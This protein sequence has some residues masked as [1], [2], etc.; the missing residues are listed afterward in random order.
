MKR[1]H[2]ESNK[3]TPPDL[4]EV[5]LRQH[6]FDLI[7]LSQP[8]R[9]AWIAGMAGSGK[10][11]L[12]AGFIKE[13]DL[14]CLWYRMD[15]DDDDLSAFFYYLGLAVKKAS[16][17]RRK[18]LPLFTP[19]YFM[20]ATAFSRRFFENVG[21]RLRAPFVIVFDDYQKV[22]RSS[23]FHEVLQNGL[24]MLP[25]DIR[26]IISSR[27]DP[28]A[29]YS[30]MI[31]GKQMIIID[32]K[33]LHLSFQETRRILR[34]DAPFP[35]SDTMVR[36]IHRAAGGWAAG[37]V[38]MAK[39]IYRDKTTALTIETAIPSE[40]FNYFAGELFNKLDGSTRE[41]LL[42][43][44]LLPQFTADMAQK[45][46]GC[47]DTPNRLAQ[48]QQDHVFIEKISNAAA[49]YQYHALFRN[50]L[51]DKAAAVLD[52]KI[53]LDLKKNSALLL[54]SSER[55]EDAVTLFAEAGDAA[56]LIRIILENAP[57]QIQLGRSKT[58]VQW[59]KR[60]PEDAREKAPWL[61]YWLGMGTLFFSPADAQTHFEKAFNHFLQEK[62]TI[63]AYLAWAGV[64]DGISNSWNDFNQFDP[65]I[66]WLE[67]ALHIRPTLPPGYIEAKVSVCMMTALLIRKPDHPDLPRWVERALAFSY[68]SEE[69]HLHVQAI[70][71]AM[72]YYAWIGEFEKAE[73]LRDTS[74]AMISSYK[75]AP[76]MTIYWKWLDISTR[77]STMTRIDTILQEIDDVLDIIRHTGLHAWEH[78]FLMP[79][80]FAA[81]LL[82]RL[83]I[84]DGFLKRF[85]TI[86]DKSHFHGFAIYHHFA[87]LYHLLAGD[88]ARA[89]ANSETAVK[90]SR[91]S[92][93]VLATIVCL[94][95][96]AFALHVQ[97]QTPAARKTIAEALKQAQAAKSHIYEF[98]C[99]MVQSRIILAQDPAKGMA[100]L[101]KALQI[102]RQHGYLNMIWWWQPELLAQLCALALRDGI[103]THYV[104][105]LIRAHS[106]L[107]ASDEDPIENW[108]YPI[109]ITTFNRFQILIDG[110]V[111]NFSRKAPKKPLELLQAVI[112]FGGID[113][114]LD[115][116]LDALWYKTDG[117]MAHS[118]FSTAL[119]RLRKLLGVQEAIELK[120]GKIT[121]NPRCGLVDALAFKSNIQKGDR[122]W[123]DHQMKAAVDHYANAI[124]LYTGPFLFGETPH[125]W[126]ITAREGLRNRFLGI[127]MKL[128][129]WHEEQSQFEKAMTYYEQGLHSD[130][131][132]E[133]LYRRLMGCQFQLGR[134]ADLVRTYQ[135]CRDRLAAGLNVAPSPETEA[136][137][138]QIRNL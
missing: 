58:L 75:G 20:G 102:G 107:P 96:L 76:A 53:L 74:R 87:G 126:I 130:D 7:D 55:I 66:S 29:A 128:G 9:I 37:L 61:H 120:N 60:L 26:V 24:A 79:G 3:I 1:R 95:Q 40:L 69:M 129:K 78:I 108:P 28:P 6:L 54:E 100:G 34:K 104:H 127:V 105:R 136:I 2:P 47:K 122:Q 123:Q 30:K 92:G 50:F 62:D 121:L 86:L 17:H 111:L 41:F 112:A 51:N 10:T 125:H 98:M 8:Y 35:L 110:T 15:E 57:Q 84:A 44:S 11:T 31:A 13:N 56:N 81:L 119:N 134:H 23:I 68:K 101:K 93:Y 106:L 91:E 116:V 80:I 42:K 45:L 25:G 135:Q 88:S 49:V 14:P 85:E 18:P 72:T 12:A 21:F 67:T 133:S 39:S 71:W 132:E 113:V 16:P 5:I 36:R 33:D 64:I 27:N 117:D 46:T 97:G 124:A 4:P 90:L 59:I 63:G 32:A 115:A 114:P 83:E 137:F 138:S 118:A 99:L 19:E 65:W 131:L 52:K 94:I 43:T 70:N 73:T 38:L 48:L 109:K 103:E 77:L 82:G 89:L 22:H